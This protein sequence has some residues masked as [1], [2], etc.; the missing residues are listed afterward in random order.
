PADHPGRVGTEARPR[1]AMRGR[2]CDPPGA[3]DAGVRRLGPAGEAEPVHLSD[4]GVA[5]HAVAEQTRDLTR[6]FAVNPMLLEL[7]DHFVRPSHLSPRSSPCQ[8]PREYAESFPVAWRE[9]R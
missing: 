1:D 9:A 7:L 6:A 5:G 2:G 4:H 8:R 3:G